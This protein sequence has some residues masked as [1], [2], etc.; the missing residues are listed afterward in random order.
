MGRLRPPEP[1]HPEFVRSPAGSFGWL[2]DRLLHDG[3]LARLGGEGVAVLALLALAADRH[4]ASFYSRAR[5]AERL[6]LTREA[7]DEG[8]RRL[9]AVELVALRPWNAGAR[10]GVWQLLPVP[11]RQAAVSAPPRG[12]SAPTTIADVLGELGIRRNPV[13]QPESRGFS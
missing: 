4:G 11:K 8:L 10:D 3:W 2:E 5:M 12:P 1:P 13:R 9:L 7:I 6:G